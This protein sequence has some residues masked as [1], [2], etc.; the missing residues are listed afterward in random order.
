MN[1]S[2]HLGES[3]RRF[4]DDFIVLETLS[5]DLIIGAATIQK[6]NIKLDFEKETV[7][8]DRKMHRLRI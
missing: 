4:H 3:K 7:V 5:E 1:Q 2:F 8:Y 6:W